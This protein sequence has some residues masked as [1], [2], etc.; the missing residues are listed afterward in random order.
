MIF[1]LL[2]TA[3][4]LYV[5]LGLFLFFFQARL[6]YFPRRELAGT[7]ADAGLAYEEVYL[8]TTD[9]VAIHGWFV[10]AKDQKGVLLYFH[11][12]GGNISHRIEALRQFNRLGLTTLIIDYRGYGKSGGETSEEGT[13]LDAEA[14]WAELV[15][16][17]NIKPE[18]IILLGRSLGGAI[19][20]HL[21]TRISPRSIILES[22]FTSIPDRGSEIYPYFPV[23]LLSRFHYDTLRRIP[24]IGR[25]LL[26]VHSTDDE[27]VPFNHG[28]RLFDAALEPKELLVI[29]GGHN[30]AF[31][32]SAERYE[33][34]L[35]EFLSRY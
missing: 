34:G 30:D 9:G 2:I 22:T 21:A 28:Q 25:P 20:A 35:S 31:V 23:R 16:R 19:A 1:T 3:I 27:I 11:G 15:S 13:Y 6:I 29:S 26:V 12:N 32:V 5:A 18:Q 24:S 10:P 7:P 17:R 33:R 4:G 14:A 8:T